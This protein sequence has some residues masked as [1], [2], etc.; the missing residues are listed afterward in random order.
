MFIKIG[1][2][3]QEWKTISVKVND[4]TRNAI[5]LIC[6]RE[7][8]TVNKFLANIISREVEHV[9]NPK[10]LP[11]N[12]GIPQIGEN[13]LKY[14]K[15]SDNFIWQLDLG[16]NGLALLS[17]NVTFN[18]LENLQKA[19]EEGLAQRLGFQKKNKKRAVIPSKLLKYEV[20]K[21]ASART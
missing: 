21:H 12:N 4:D 5:E 1:M 11:E 14:I 16:V 20:K 13:K 9:I 2:A 18:Y 8:I 17:D 6:K 10:V 3:I 15:E 19:I 7:R